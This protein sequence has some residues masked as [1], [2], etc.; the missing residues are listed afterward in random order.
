MNHFYAKS[1]RPMAADGDDRPSAKI[2]LLGATMVGKTTLINRLT[3]GDF[4]SSSQVTV[5]SC[6]SSRVTEVGATRI[7]LQIWDTAGQ[8]R[9]KTLVPMYFRGAAAALVVYSVVDAT[10]FRDV[11]FWAARVKEDSNSA[12][13]LFL[14]ANKT[15]LPQ[16]Q[17]I[18][19]AG[20]D[21][22][23]TH[24]A[25]FYE[26]SAASGIGL[27]EMIQRVAEV[28]LASTEK[29]RAA[30]IVNIKD[31]PRIKKTRRPC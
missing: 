21:A 12:P 6:Y 11:A 20:Q 3:N 5:G 28:A 24:G 31:G 18:I 30:T 22:A 16:R 25:E 17:G 2:V 14:I 8:E 13:T 7:T 29:K 9:F 1:S 27:D 15:D 26:V 4:D 10:S 23:T 19:A